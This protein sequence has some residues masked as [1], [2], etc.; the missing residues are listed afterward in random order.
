LTKSPALRTKLWLRGRVRTG[1]AESMCGILGWFGDGR[2]A[3]ADRFRCAVDSMTH[4]GPDD[5][6]VQRFDHSDGTAVLLGHRRLSIL[7][8]SP[9]GHQPMVSPRTGAAIVFNGEIYN[10]QDL[11]DELQS[12]GYAFRSTCDT[13]VLLAAY[14]E[15]GAECVRRLNGIFAFG[16]WDP[17]SRKFLAARDHLGI[18]PLF[19]YHDG[20][21]FAFASELTAAVAA[22]GGKLTLQPEAAAE[23]FAYGYLSRNLTL[24]EN[25]FRVPPGH[26]LEYDTAAR[27]M[28]I[29]A[30]W[31]PMD[32][33]LAPE[34]TGDEESLADELEALLADA[35]RR[36]L[37]SDV[38][39]GAFLSGGIDSTTVVA[40]MVKAASVRPKTYS[41]GFTLPE[42]DEAPWAKRIA[43]H[44]GT[45]H[46]EEY[47]SPKGLAD[48]IID[49]AATHD[50][51]FGD[52]SAI[53][54]TVLC[55]MTRR[56]V[57]VALSGDGG[58]ELF[59]GYDRYRRG[60]QYQSF[61][62]LPV[63]VRWAVAGLLGRMPR[64]RMRQWARA[65]SAPT[66]VELHAETSR[67]RG[68]RLLFPGPHE[69]VW[70]E[71]ARRIFDALGPSRWEKFMPA[72]D[73]ATYMPEDI[74]EKVDRA[75]MSVALEARV[76]MLDYR[77]A[78]F[79]ARLPHRMKFRGGTSKYLL[80]KVLARHVPRE[81]WERPK[82]GFSIPLG[83]WFRKDLR[84]WVQDELTGNW[85]WTCGVIN[86]DAARQIINDHMAGRNEYSRLIWCFLSWRS[87]ARRIG[88]TK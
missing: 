70:D 39:L 65:L 76:P 62:R 55:R 4:R 41:I 5:S 82:S 75:S 88:L 1:K 61:R 54:T 50:E 81:M 32:F 59:F 64:P 45:E 6:G 71:T 42:W 44:L 58:D 3:S 80:R 26:L 14:D 27:S 24:L 53:P 29:R 36:Q 38:P 30:Y 46:H 25:Y 74:L 72:V 9:L 52:T 78:E 77:V 63:A 40:L 28:H 60:L 31:D 22:V 37:V 69:F 86:R 73:T 8:L 21:T 10:F 49:V 7:D 11:R 20:Q 51:P 83:E 87:W 66:L 15:W 19:G 43:E 35:V 85:D 48:A 16:I 12:K 79:A 13:E 47:V 84:T 18:K 17:R 34:L 23:F 2:R 33:M 57:T 68:W 56:H 67:Q